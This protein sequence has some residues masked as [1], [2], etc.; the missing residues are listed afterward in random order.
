MP[1]C[2]Q[3]GRLG[4]GIAASS[5]GTNAVS[6]RAPTVRGRRVERRLPVHE[7]RSR[8]EAAVDERAKPAIADGPSET[9][10]RHDVLS[11]RRADDRDPHHDRPIPIGN[12]ATLPSTTSTTS[13]ETQSPGW[14]VP[15]QVAS[16]L[17]R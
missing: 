13:R 15:I 4:C 7:A 14:D 12:H 6:P 10:S 3:P 11:G 1:E 2:D 8:E 9:K 5:D 16:A 17:L